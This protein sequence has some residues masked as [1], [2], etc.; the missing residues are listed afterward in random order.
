MSV[1]PVWMQKL[2]WPNCSCDNS[3]RA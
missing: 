1:H 3:D 2:C